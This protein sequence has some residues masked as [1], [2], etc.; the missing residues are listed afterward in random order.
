MTSRRRVSFDHATPAWVDGRRLYFTT[1]CTVPRGLDQL[2]HPDTAKGIFAATNHYHS[3]G[4][5]HV[6]LMLLMP[7]HVHALLGFPMNESM[8]Q[9]VSSWKHYLSA[10]YHIAWQRDFFEHRL[11]N[12]EGHEEK[13]AYIRNN[14]VRAG[15]VSA[16]EEWPYVW[17]P[18]R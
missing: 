1:I 3:L 17:T 12:H 14:P 13:T 4:R 2:C 8:S 10:K 11:R 7:D 9:V 5:W 18:K 15:L 6:E 16:P